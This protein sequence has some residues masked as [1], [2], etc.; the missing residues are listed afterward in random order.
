M[1]T[2]SAVRAPWTDT[3]DRAAA[4]LWRLVVNR[5][6]QRRRSSAH[7]PLVASYRGIAAVHP[8]DPDGGGTWVAVSAAG[9]AMVLLNGVERPGHSEGRPEGLRYVWGSRQGRV[10]RGLIIPQLLGARSI[11]EAR[12]VLGDMTVV[13]YRPFRL[14]V[15]SDDAVLECVS[16]GGA[17]T[18]ALRWPAPRLVRTS[19]SVRSEEVCGLR[20]HLFGE[21]VP[22]PSR[23]MQDAFHAHRW[24]MDRAAS[25]LMDRPDARTVSQT[26]IE[27]LPDR[28]RL[29]YRRVPAWSGTVTEIPRKFDEHPLRDTRTRSASR[30]L[31]DQRPTG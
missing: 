26:V 3:A 17:L 2:V 18:S 29:E 25:V 24:D 7:P 30:H 31:D 28:A 22:Q 15:L 12:S 16:A 20:S 1:C 19:S 10:S 6:E 23:R 13:R 11:E 14:L 21:M 9:L 27:M 8:V 5:D 4:I